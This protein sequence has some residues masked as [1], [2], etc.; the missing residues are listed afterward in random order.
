DLS[1]WSH[2][3]LSEKDVN[4]F[5]Q[6]CTH[7]E[8]LEI[9]GLSTPKQSNLLLMTFPSIK[10]LEL[11]TEDDPTLEFIQRCP[12][13]TSIK[14]GYGIDRTRFASSF[15]ELVT[16]KTWPHL[17]SV[18]MMETGIA[19]DDILRII[20]G[21]QRINTFMINY[22]SY[23]FGSDAMEQLR[24]HFS[25][26]RVLRLHHRYVK[27]NSRI[28]QEILTS[29]PLLEQLTAP[30]IDASVVAE[31]NPWVCTRLQKL[32]LIFFYE[33][34]ALPRLQ[35]LLFDQLARLVRLEEW[36]MGYSHAG[37]RHQQVDL[38]LENGLGKLS[39]LRSLRSID[40]GNTC[41][42]I[43]QQEIDWILEHWTE[44]ENIK[45]RRNA[46]VNGVLK[47]RM[48]EHGITMS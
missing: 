11:S 30:P 27:S 38:T 18:S 46:S 5:W 44:L 45:Y 7:L 47:K 8:R 31:G 21:I 34:S 10:E 36:C 22:S 3:K 4:T 13:L 42:E 16:V 43:G 28:A 26:I 35:P 17:H 1:F 48:M 39:T 32:R 14:Y 15:S 33:D 25:N 40:F 23:S 41:Q 6:L 20:G 9:H 29:C 24:P 2:L 12:N 37:F 19:E